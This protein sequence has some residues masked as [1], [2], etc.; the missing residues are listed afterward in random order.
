M[1][2]CQN[3]EGQ[4]ILVCFDGDDFCGVDHVVDEYVAGASGARGVVD[5]AVGNVEAGQAAGEAAAGIGS[6]GAGDG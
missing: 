1:F 5:G 4:L 6:E 2:Q 3:A